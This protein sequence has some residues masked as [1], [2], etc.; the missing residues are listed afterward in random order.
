MGNMISITKRLLNGLLW[1]VTALVV[2]NI[3]ACLW[4]GHNGPWDV[5]S[6]YQHYASVPLCWV[7]AAIIFLFGAYLG[8]RQRST[9][10]KKP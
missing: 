9:K 4:A 7:A 5:V 1:G 8:A 10:E 3:A 6:F 2:A